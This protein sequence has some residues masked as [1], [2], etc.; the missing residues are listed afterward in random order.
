MTANQNVTANVT[1]KKDVYYIVV[2]YYQNGK[3][4]QKWV[5]TDLAVSG[6]N[7]RKVEQKRIEVLQ[8]WQEKVI[9]NDIGMLF[10]DYLKLWI[11]E[12]KH[13]ISKNT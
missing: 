8:E 10:S 12:T 7:K 11:E 9:F 1:S 3:R 6:N 13:T 5:K 4:K 2:S